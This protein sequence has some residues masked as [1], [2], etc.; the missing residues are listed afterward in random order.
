MDL[1]IPGDTARE[2]A[3]VKAPAVGGDGIPAPYDTALIPTLVVRKTGAAWNNPFA[4]VYEPHFGAG[5][6]TVTNVT[7]LLRTNVVVGLKIESTVDGKSLVHYV[8]SNPGATETYT[9]T[10]IGLTFKG[11]FGV[12]A[13]NGDGT[14]SL[15]LG[16]GSSLSYRG[17]SVAAVGGA[18]TQAEVRFVPGQTPQITAN[19]PVNVL[20]AKAPQFTLI[21]RQVDGVISL[22]ATGSNGVPYRLWSST[23]LAGGVWTTLSSGTVTNSPFVIQD[24][25]AAAISARYYRFS[26][27]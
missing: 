20:A 25:G 6:G 12:V 14:T 9:N 19:A 22:Q 27:P 10:A 18:N 26:T 5:G 15:Y 3:T 17:N 7:T 8:F 21:T 24:A 23:N 1:H 16:Q 13:D 4:V 11:R 2:Y